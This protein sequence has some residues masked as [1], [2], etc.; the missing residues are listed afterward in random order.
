MAIKIVYKLY[1]SL[2]R[3]ANLLYFTKFIN[4]S[5]QMLETW[6]QLFPDY[7]STFVSD[8]INFVS[9]IF[10]VYMYTVEPRRQV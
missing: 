6:S 1:I 9:C 10:T 3:V 5:A 8:R 4:Y 7:L 2:L